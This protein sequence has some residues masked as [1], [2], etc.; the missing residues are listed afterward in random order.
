MDMMMSFLRK[1]T[2]L[3]TAVMLLLSCVSAALA[4]QQVPFGGNGGK[5]SL[6]VNFHHNNETGNVDRLEADKNGNKY[7]VKK[8]QD[9]VWEGHVFLGWSTSAAA[10]KADVEENGNSKIYR[11]DIKDYPN[12]EVDVYAVWGSAAPSSPTTAKYTVQ[13][14]QQNL[15][16]DGYTLVNGDTQELTG[17]INDTVT[18]KALKYTGFT[19]DSGVA[20]TKASG[21][22]TADGGLALKLYYRRNTHNVAYQYTGKLIPA[23]AP[24]A[25]A[26]SQTG[27]RYG[28]D[29]TVAASPSITGYTF[30][31]W[32]T[33]D[34]SV[35]G[36]SFTMPDKGVTLTGSF[37]YE[38]YTIAYEAGDKGTLQ[39]K[40]SYGNAHIDETVVRAG[41][42]APAV[43][44]SNSD[45][46]FT[47][48]WLLKGT[49]AVY[50]TDA[51][52]SLPVTGSMTF[53]AQYA[54][55]DTIVISVT[56]VEREYAKTEYAT[57]EPVVKAPEGSG[58]TWAVVEAAKA[59][60]YTPAKATNVRLTGGMVGSYPAALEIKKTE[61]TYNGKVYKI[62]KGQVGALTITQ[63]P[64]TM[65]STGLSK[66]YDGLKLTNETTTV[67]ITGLL[68]GDKLFYDHPLIELTDVDSVDNTFSDPKRSGGFNVVDNYKV[69]KRYGKLTVAAV[70]LTVATP[71][72]GRAYNGAPLTQAV[73]LSVKVV[74]DTYRVAL[75]APDA[76]GKASCT[77]D[78][79]NGITETF[80]VAV[81]GTITN[82]GSVQNAYSMV[83]G[84]VKAKNYTL[85][86]NLGTLTITQA[87]LALVADDQSAV[88]GEP[89]PTLTYHFWDTV[90]S[91]QVTLLASELMGAP[92]LTTTAAQGSDAAEYPI[93]IS[94]GTL[95]TS[96][97]CNYSVGADPKTY[98]INGKLT[99]QKRPVSVTLAVGETVYNAK[100]Q[101]LP[102]QPG[103]AAPND[104]QTFTATTAE[105]RTTGRGLLA[106]DAVSVGGGAIG[107]RQTYVNSVNGAVKPYSVTVAAADV[108]VL[109]GTA[110]PVDVT[111]NYALQ[112]NEGQFTIQRRSI[113]V[114]L[115]VTNPNA[116]YASPWY[117][118][119]WDGQ[120]LKLR[121]DGGAPAEGDKLDF[122]TPN[123]DG[124]LPADS[125]KIN[126]G[127]VATLDKTDEL[128]TYHFSYDSRNPVIVRNGKGIDVSANYNFNRQA[129]S[130]KV[131]ASSQPIIVTVEGNTESFVYDGK[132]HEVNG[133]TVTIAGGNGLYTERDITF[134]GTA[135]AVLTDFG[136]Q[137]MGLLASQFSD[138][139]SHFSDV[140][141]NVTDGGVSV[142]QRPVTLI[143]E[144]AVKAY[145][146]GEQ[147][148][149]AM[150]ANGLVAGD[151][152]SGLSYSAK[153]TN[154]SAT[155]YGGAFSGTL[156]I[157]DGTGK[158]V[159]ANYAPVMQA[160]ALTITP[161]PVTVTA[162]GKTKAYGAADPALTAT[163]NGL[164]N[165]DTVAYT[166]S[167]VAGEAAGT[168]VITPA[169]EKLQGNYEVAYHLGSLEIL[170]QPAETATVTYLYYYNGVQNAAETVTLTGYV[171]Y[172]ITAYEAKP[173]GMNLQR[174][175][176]LDNLID[177]DDDNNI[178]RIYYARNAYQIIADTPTALAGSF[179]N[180]TVG[181]VLE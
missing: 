80:T 84:A 79:Q 173:N 89:I 162:D 53:V 151:A 169:G 70:K 47:D 160:G 147:T 66:T 121:L 16:D 111:K 51:L 98:W 107:D 137:S 4:G 143:G 50:D 38:A 31:G 119:P 159:T 117:A 102:L 48:S 14:Y 11:F 59:V 13:H 99:I 150:T 68:P 19:Y 69:T 115:V 6:T 21:E 176:G 124:S 108:A 120:P 128:G 35:V 136:T 126:S 152:L 116:I 181:D 10:Q 57:G 42:P 33:K 135:S 62:S 171:G 65:E 76:E 7:Q 139:S 153:G 82:V 105:G 1:T 54:L 106:G 85:S 93:E 155:P 87:P 97:T 91:R 100:E 145:N 71:T 146:G 72:A 163:V 165:T 75:S 144:T 90:A 149:T 125:Y 164:L 37:G 140:T 34:A 56:N 148:L 110:N 179:M 36:G 20:G 123:G 131:T 141:F 15:N 64:V 8:E 63:R 24:D 5:D 158:A 88:Y 49:T 172:P 58:V 104:F 161:A 40:A 23:G 3:L 101:T 132:P 103:A 27:V 46:Y 156:A 175:T 26:Y 9:P 43:K 134:T 25:S 96:S 17:K 52:A 178:V 45:Y 78:F 2:A 83:W 112:T 170:P 61:L 129:P 60:Q 180:V 22:V 30:S 130:V 127:A 109:R 154:A 12:H 18:A 118:K 157:T 113:T 32:A 174:V 138:S 92:V 29:V 168:Y 55:K 114:E 167:R 28:A 74:P 44:V 39:G 177:S 166:L 94:A 41:R 77:V 133:Y 95:Q 81:T 142:A 86:S 122:Q 73:G 67:N